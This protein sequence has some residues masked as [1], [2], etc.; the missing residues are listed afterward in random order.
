MADLVDHRVAV[1]AAPGAGASALAAKAATQ[2]IPIVFMMGVDAVDFGLV[3]SLAHP[4]GNLTG[5][6]Q[7]QTRY[8]A[9]AAQTVLIVLGEI[10]LS[11][12]LEVL[13]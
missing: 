4:G 10:P 7:L 11:K 13:H 5:V 6:A 9:K 2:T 8:V 12:L 3:E 1:V